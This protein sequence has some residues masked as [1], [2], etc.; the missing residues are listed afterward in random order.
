VCNTVKVERDEHTGDL[1][2]QAS[3]PDELALL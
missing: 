1:S 3:S 2:Y